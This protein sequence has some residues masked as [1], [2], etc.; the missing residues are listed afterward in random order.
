MTTLPNSARDQT[1]WVTSLQSLGNGGDRRVRRYY[2]VQAFQIPSVLIW[3]HAADR[4]LPA[5]DKLCYGAGRTLRFPTPDPARR[6]HRVSLPGESSQHFVKRVIGVPGDRIY[7]VNKRVF[8]NGL[9]P[10]G[11]RVRRKETFRDDFPR[12]DV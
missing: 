5:V 11:V 4:R 6:H 10:G 2:I 9:L 3:E 1:D 7:L 12:L 8:V